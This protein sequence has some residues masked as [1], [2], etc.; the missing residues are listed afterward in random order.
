MSSKSLPVGKWRETRKG[1]TDGMISETL[2]GYKVI[3]AT[4][5]GRGRTKSS[6]APSVGPM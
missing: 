1:F 6:A 3:I 4:S 2:I 5:R